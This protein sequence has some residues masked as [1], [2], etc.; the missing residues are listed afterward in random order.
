M[1]VSHDERALVRRYVRSTW[2]P[3]EC[4]YDV[5]WTDRLTG[6]VVFSYDGADPANTNPACGGYSDE[7]AFA[8]KG[9]DIRGEIPACESKLPVG[10]YEAERW[11]L[12]KERQAVREA[13]EEA[14][15]DL[16]Y[17]LGDDWPEEFDFDRYHAGEQ[18]LLKPALEAKGYTGIGFYMG[19]QD[20]FGPLSRGCVA[21]DP[22]GARVRFYYG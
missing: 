4:T 5:I 10:P 3:D 6:L 21:T 2:A 13:E 20:S 9:L 12:T 15:L 11:A 19:E 16:A 7:E 18:E 17:F 14:A 8:R 22:S 1:T